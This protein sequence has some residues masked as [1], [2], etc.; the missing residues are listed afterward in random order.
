M[1]G[2]EKDAI[3]VG[4]TISIFC[5]TPNKRIVEDRL[6]YGLFWFLIGFTDFL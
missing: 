4:G 5:N 3:V 1:K 2:E 6:A